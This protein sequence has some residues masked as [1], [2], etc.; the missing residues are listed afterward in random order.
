MN[1]KNEFEYVSIEMPVAILAKI[2]D[3]LQDEL[4]NAVFEE[5]YKLA[6]QI[7]NALEDVSAEM[8]GG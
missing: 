5:N 4:E 1:R 3:K 2:K 7:L 6:R 8:N